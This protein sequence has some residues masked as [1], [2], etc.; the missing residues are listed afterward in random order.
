MMLRALVATT[1]PMRSSLPQPAGTVRA[2]AEVKNAGWL[3]GIRVRRCDR[4]AKDQPAEIT[5]FQISEVQELP[6]FNGRRSFLILR[7]HGFLNA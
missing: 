1:T 4:L 5:M 2:D 3:R 7:S 6:A